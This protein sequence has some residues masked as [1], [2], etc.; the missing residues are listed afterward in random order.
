MPRTQK[1]ACVVLLVRVLTIF[2]VLLG[3]VAPAMAQPGQGRGYD[4]DRASA[5]I[6]YNDRQTI[7]QYLDSLTRQPSAPSAQHC[8]PGLAKKNNGCL[9]PGIAK[10]YALGQPLPPGLAKPLPDA[11]RG[12]LSRPRPG[13]DYVMVDN[14]VLLIAEAGKMVIDA[15]T[16]LSAV[17]GK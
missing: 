14:D 16:L 10:K 1:P 11:L 7:R 9:P 17:G 8:P 2:L 6:S 15:V 13:Y 4:G 12:R 3:G 5:R